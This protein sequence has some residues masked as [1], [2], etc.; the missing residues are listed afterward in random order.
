MLTNLRLANLRL[1]TA[2]QRTTG[3]NLPAD[4]YATVLVTKEAT[5][6]HCLLAVTQPTQRACYFRDTGYAKAE[7]CSIVFGCE[8]ELYG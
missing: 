8:S 4:L 2:Q 5:F 3:Q 1:T 7:P 6:A